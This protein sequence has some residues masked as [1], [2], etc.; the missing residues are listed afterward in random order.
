MHRKLCTNQCLG[1]RMHRMLGNILAWNGLHNMSQ[2]HNCDLMGKRADQSQIMTNKDHTDVLFF[3]QT[4]QKLDNRFLYGN[5]QRRG[6]LV[7]DQNLRLQ[8]KSSGNTDS[9]TLSATH[10]MGIT[11]CKIL[12][13][14]NHAKK[15]SCLCVSFASFD[16]FVVHQRLCKNVPNFHFGVK[17]CKGI[18]E[19]HLQI[20]AVFP[21]FFSGK[22]CDVFSMVKDL[23]AGRLIQGGY[24]ADKCGLSASALPYNS[25]SSS[26]VHSQIDI[27]AGS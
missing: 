9:L 21:G 3:L 2:I 24:H 16:L 27:I 8:G 12:R 6:R 23:A 15:L 4:H 22:S 5:V 11:V 13:K 25:K 20:L 17:G 7:A 1:I 14:L 26:F 19:N 18:L 10:V